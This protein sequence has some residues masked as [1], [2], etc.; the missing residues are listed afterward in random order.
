VIAFSVA[1][2]GSLFSADAWNN[3]TFTAGEVK[4][5][6]R[7]V[8]LS[9]AAGT[10]IVIA[11]YLLANLAYLLTLPLA[12]I[13]SAPGD[14]VASATLGVIFGGAGAAIMALAIMVSTF[15]CAN[16]LILA[17]SRVYFAMAQDKLFFRSIG[18]LNRRHVPAKG[19]MLQGI[20]AAFLVLMRTRIVDPVSGN[21]KY[22][23]LYSDLLDY[24]VFA[25]LIFY[26]LTIFGLFRL[27]R[28]RPDA[29]R[30][31]RAFGYPIVPVLY[32]AGALVIMTVLLL[33]Q[34]QTAWPGLVIV[35]LGI[36][37]YLIW[38]PKAGAKVASE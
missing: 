38:S 18:K 36:P 21:V 11:L 15:G 29:E 37:V 3:I 19:L 13:Q 27:R 2:V 23:N 32:I 33:Y 5:P 31:Y 4:N 10:A 34:T 17:G 16:G 7:D 1:Q 22:G 14:R 30:P 28:S 26:V 12:Q 9:L 25:V 35:L 24:V 8:P 6:R 20:W